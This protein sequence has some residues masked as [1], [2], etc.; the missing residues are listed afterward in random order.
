MSVS[1]ATRLQT[2][3]GRV[4]G[5][6]SNG[7]LGQLLSA[8]GSV[9]D[10]AHLDGQDAIAQLNLLSASD[11]WLD[12]WGGLFKV[13]RLAGESDVLYAPRIIAQVIRPRTQWRAIEEIVQN[14]F[15]L[16]IQIRDLYPYCLLSD[17]FVTPAGRPPQ[18]CD[19]QLTDGFNGSSP[20]QAVRCDYASPYMAG[21]F[22]VWIQFTSSSTPYSF[23]LSDI[24]ANFPLDLFSDDF[25][26]TDKMVSDGQVGVPSYGISFG[27]VTPSPP[28]SQ[29]DVLN[30]INENR[31]AGTQAFFME[32]TKVG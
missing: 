23:T 28:F 18:V 14:A 20:D 2:N 17:Q 21:N 5:A 3:M 15:N 16:T 1:T 19:G 13:P 12:Q 25:T 27:P 8:I 22:G 32:I 31:A 26:L 11:E 7:V 10:R 6:P 30:L 29:A 4:Y 24:R 9:I